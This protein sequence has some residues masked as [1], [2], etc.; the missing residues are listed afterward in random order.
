LDFILFDSKTWSNSCSR[1]QRKMQRLKPRRRKTEKAKMK[2]KAQ[3]KVRATKNSYSQE[4]R[5]RV[6]RYRK[7]RIGTSCF[8]HLEQN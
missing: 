3:R 5:A 2:M 4:Q 1:W 6:C 8:L 7:K